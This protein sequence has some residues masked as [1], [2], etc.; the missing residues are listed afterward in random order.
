MSPEDV[1]EDKAA[2]DR[3]SGKREKPKKPSL[4][5]RAEASKADRADRV[6]EEMR[7]NLLKRK[8]QQRSKQSEV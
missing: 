3:R 4:T 8:Q 5:P 1:F 6:A 2:E 7:K